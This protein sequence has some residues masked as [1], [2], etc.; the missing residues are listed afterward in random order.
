M[1]R[2][3]CLAGIFAVKGDKCRKTRINGKS[4]S[5]KF[6]SH[7]DF[8]LEG[9]ERPVLVDCWATWCKNCSMMD[10]T[11]LSDPRVKEVF[12]KRK[13]TLVK[14]QAEDM[15]ALRQISGFQDVIGLPAF[16]IFE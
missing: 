13:M 16:L 7:K 10:K 2:L 9:I 6:D 4:P 12:K 14:L 8:T 11:T 1:V 15:A 5:V 3:S